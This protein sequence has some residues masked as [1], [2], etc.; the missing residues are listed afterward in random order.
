MIQHML[1]MN[2]A[3]PLIVLASPGIAFLWALPLRQRRWIGSLKRRGQ[4]GRLAHYLL[5]QP[6]AL[7]A[8]F[9]LTLWVWHLPALYETALHN[10]LFHDLQHFMFFASAALFWRVLLDPVSRRRLSR[11]GAVAYLFV[12]S[13]HATFLGVFMALAPS[14][15]Y[16]TYEGRT[17]RWNLSALQDQQ[18][19]GLI[20]WM[21]ACMTYA[22]VVAIVLPIWLSRET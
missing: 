9:A 19:A 15:W 17:M 13:M 16:A 21:P 2:I 14:V 5:W 1:I 6:V 12:T 8:L 11:I 20:M 10:E 7:C 3:A 4:P 18:L 22:V